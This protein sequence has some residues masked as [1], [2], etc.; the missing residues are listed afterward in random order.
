MNHPLKKVEVKEVLGEEIGKLIKEGNMQAIK[1]IKADETSIKNIQDL[2]VKSTRKGVCMIFLRQLA[3]SEDG[4]KA[5]GIHITEHDSESNS[6]KSRLLMQ[7]FETG[8]SLVFNYEYQNLGCALMVAETLNLAI[9]GGCDQKPVLHCLQTGKTLK[10]LDLGVG[11]ICCFFRFGSVV[12]VNADEEVI[13]LDLTT[14]KIKDIS[15]I[16]IEPNVICMQSSIRNSLEDKDSPQPILFL[17]GL[18][19]TKLTRI[20]VPKI[21]ISK[22]NQDFFNLI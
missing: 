21:I 11:G 12:A 16:K 1:R 2:Q 18:K 22:S 4:S 7:N 17:G 10:V 15:Q 8:K 9:T 6:Q 14:Q 5:W 19:S 20:I 13:F 3:V